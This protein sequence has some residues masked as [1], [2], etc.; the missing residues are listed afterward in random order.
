M[1]FESS[2]PV[3][4]G[5]RAPSVLAADAGGGA[6]GG[7]GGLKEL[8]D[9]NVVNDESSGR[10]SEN[11]TRE[12]WTKMLMAMAWMINEDSTLKPIRSGD[13]ILL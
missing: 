6:G 7:G 11:Q 1:N 3:V 13:S 2:S 12:P 10:S 9:M 5:R 4:L 8:A